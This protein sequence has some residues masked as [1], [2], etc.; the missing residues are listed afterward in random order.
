VVTALAAKY[1]PAEP[2]L[3]SP[4]ADLPAAGREH[5]PFLPVR[6]PAVIAS[7]WLR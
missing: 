3:R 6:L 5:H 4:S 1:P 2:I 7:R